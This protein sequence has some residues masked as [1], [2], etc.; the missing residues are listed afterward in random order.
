[1]RET[2]DDLAELGSAQE[3]KAELADR[4]AKMQRDQTQFEAEV[5][6]LAGAIGL[7]GGRSDVLALCEEVVNSVAFAT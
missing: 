5:E 3:R 7:A 6:A 1:V 2:L 4:I